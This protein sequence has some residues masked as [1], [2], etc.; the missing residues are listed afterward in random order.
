M[1]TVRGISYLVGDMPEAEMRRDLSI[2]ARYLHCTTVMLIA[3]DRAR[4][5]EAARI[6]LETGLGVYLR[7]HVPDLPQPELLQHLDTVAQAAEELRLEHPDRVTLLVGSEFTHTAPGIVPGP[8]SFLRLKVILRMHRLLRRRLDRR[9]HTLLSAA[10][11]TARHRF[12]GPLT[13][14]AAG[15]EHVD[16]SLFDL[17]GVSLYRGA[18]NHAGYSDR[19]RGLIQDHDK[20]V[21][22]TEFGCGAFTGADLRGAGSFQIVNWFAASPHIRGDHPRD[23]TVQARYL[24]EL[25][26]LYNTEGVYGCFVFTF[27]MPDFPHRDDP[28]L[29]L[30]KAGFGILAVSESTPRRPK[31]AFHEVAQCYSDT[32]TTTQQEH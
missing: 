8:R 32:N 25:I 16:W 13:Y 23:E 5:I 15:W 26:D 24:R 30:D 31:A 11:A 2:I 22:I 20:P 21:V 14:S 29:D 9:L 18:R 17:V 12:H 27:A 7:P 19:L 6:A 1:L 3:G 4:L 28:R 10:A